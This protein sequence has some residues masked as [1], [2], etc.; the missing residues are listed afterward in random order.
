MF[1]SLIKKH[2]ESKILAIE[3]EVEIISGL[4]VEEEINNENKSI[5]SKVTFQH[6]IKTQSRIRKLTTT[7]MLYSIIFS[8][9]RE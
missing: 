4:M 6:S 3:K 9:I 5:I 2:I 8:H 7:I 1:K